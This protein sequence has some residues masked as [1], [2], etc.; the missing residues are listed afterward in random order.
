VW[1]ELIV[2]AGV[3]A[4][5]GLRSFAYDRYR[6]W[7]AWTPGRF[8]I[9][10][11]LFAFANAAGA[12]LTVAVATWLDWEPRHGSWAYNG[13]VYALITVGLVRIEPRVSDLRVIEHGRSVLAWAQRFVEHF[14][15]RGCEGRFQRQ[16]HQLSD[17]QL[18]DEA[19]YLYGKFVASDSE[20]PKKA[21]VR[22]RKTLND[23]AALLADGSQDGRGTLEGYCLAE[24][25]KRNLH[26]EMAWMASLQPA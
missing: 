26:P 2:A 18:F 16:L 13:L 10:L 8:P 12:A 4:L 7:R 20:T 6:Y 19:M 21:R 14:L 1:R 24:V 15:D 22:Q 9:G 17:Q 25:A 3:S 5:L 23:A 11:G